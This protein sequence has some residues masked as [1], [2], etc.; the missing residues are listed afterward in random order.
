MREKEIAFG[1]CTR[2]T[3]Y[4][5]KIKKDIHR[6]RWDR[7]R[8]REREKER[9]SNRERERERGREREREGGREK[10]IMNKIKIDSWSETSKLSQC[11]HSVTSGINRWKSRDLQ[12]QT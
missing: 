10:Q 5:V 3:Y 2:V 1:S 12:M 6:E 11:H 9:E 4:L 8:K 7:E